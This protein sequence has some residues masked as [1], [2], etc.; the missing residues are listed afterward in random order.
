[1]R[2]LHRFCPTAL[3]LSTLE[4]RIALSHPGSAVVAAVP[5]PQYSTVVGT[6]VTTL[7]TRPGGDHS[8]TLVGRGLYLFGP[9][10]VVSHLTS[11][12]S[13]R[14]PDGNTEGVLMVRNLKRPGTLVMV[15]SGAPSS[16]ENAHES[17]D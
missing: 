9:T 3:S 11:N 7:P 10:H 5:R 1:M 6:A 16:L 12:P 4:D 17:L 2:R 13:I 15:V 8:T 14:A